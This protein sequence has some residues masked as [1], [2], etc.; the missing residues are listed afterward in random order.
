MSSWAARAIVSGTVVLLA[1]LASRALRPADLPPLRFDL[2]FYGAPR[3]LG[4]LLWIKT[5]Q[6]VSSPSRVTP[7]EAY[8]HYRTIQVAAELHPHYVE[9][10]LCGIIAMCMWHR[11]D[12]AIDLVREGVERFPADRN[13]RFAAF[14]VVTVFGVDLERLLRAVPALEI[15]TSEAA[16]SSGFMEA[17]EIVAIFWTIKARK[18]EEEGRLEEAL[19]IWRKI[20][21]DYSYNPAFVD[22]ASGAIERIEREL[23]ERGRRSS[24]P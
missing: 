11:T 13:I 7:S 8:R 6:R 2:R 21:A 22:S 10:Y 20:L 23:A 4:D 9:P 3:A 12:L 14:G 16:R 24:G 1:G 17:N 15:P 5:A 19:A 18:A